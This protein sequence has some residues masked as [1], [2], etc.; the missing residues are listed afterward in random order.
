MSI[1]DIKNY[2]FG[3][4][5]GAPALGGICPPCPPHCY[6]T[7]RCTT[8]QYTDDDRSHHIDQLLLKVARL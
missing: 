6:A 2:Y 3:R 5:L 1:W 4:E 7:V 8:L